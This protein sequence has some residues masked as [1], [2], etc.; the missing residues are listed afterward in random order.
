[1]AEVDI[2]WVA[3]L[4]AALVG[5]PVSGLWY[6]PLFGDAW[7]RSLGLDSVVVKSQPRWPSMRCSNRSRCRTSSSTVLTGPSLSR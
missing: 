5:L 2:N 6:G 1:M 4:A 7:M 3:V